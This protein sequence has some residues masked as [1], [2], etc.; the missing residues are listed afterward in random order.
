M[1]VPA[2]ELLDQQPRQTEAQSV[3]HRSRGQEQPRGDALHRRIEALPQ[4]LIRREQFA[5]PV[6][7]ETRGAVP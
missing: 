7:K 2:G 3:C 6:L 4:E 1:D 5:A